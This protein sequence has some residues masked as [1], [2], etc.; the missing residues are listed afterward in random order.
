MALFITLYLVGFLRTLVIIAVIYFGFRFVVRYI[1]PKIIDKG[2][3]NMQQKMQEQQRQ[4]QPKRP[5][6]EVTVENRRSNNRN[7]PDKGEYVDFEEVD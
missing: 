4:Q 5:E 2:M 6:G 3:K 7:N 1:F